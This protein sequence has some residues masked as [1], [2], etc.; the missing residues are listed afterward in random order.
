MF[1][2]AD[3]IMVVGETQLWFNQMDLLDSLCHQFFFFA[4]S[5]QVGQITT[6]QF[7]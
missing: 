3:L 4:N 7:C 5:L 1:D 2:D 6:T